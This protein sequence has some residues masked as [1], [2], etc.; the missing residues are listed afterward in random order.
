MHVPWMKKPADFGDPLTF[1][2]A[3]PSGQTTFAV[4]IRARGGCCALAEVYREH[5][6]RVPR[7]DLLH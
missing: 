4:R 3:P 7:I 1:P 2:V 5:S 6:F